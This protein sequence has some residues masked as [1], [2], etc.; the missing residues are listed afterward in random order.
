MRIKTFIKFLRH[1]HI[2]VA[3]VF[4]RENIRALTGIDC[5]D[6]CLE[7]TP[8]S[9]ALYTDF[10]YWAM[11]RRL[12]PDMNLRDIR[13]LGEGAI[14]RASRVGFE[15]S[16]PYSSYARILKLSNDAEFKDVEKK[17]LELRAVKTPAEIAMIAKAERLT[18]N[19]WREGSKLFRPGMS[20]IGMARILKKFMI[21]RAD[22][23][24]FETIVCIGENAAECHH[25]PDGTVWDGVKPVLVDL[26]V[27][28]GGVC[29][30]LTRNLVPAGASREYRRIY[31]IVK[32]ANREAIAAARPGIAADR[33]DKIARDIIADAGYGECFGHS[34]GHGVGY[35]IHEAPTLSRRNHT[36]LAPGMVVTIEPGI[37]LEGEAGVRI[38]DLVVITE[39]GCKVLSR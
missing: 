18:L 27:R 5:D 14:S 36:M 10:R 2:D 6:A 11:V 12:A 31:S 17:I 1:G 22:A 37:Y 15:G 9:V 8:E 21:E 26:G 4:K 32:K 3:L 33:L 24:A 39:N 7:V 29:S 19:I 20:E 13:K 35:E 23:E 38:E 28:L 25:V 16:I 30:D 34:L